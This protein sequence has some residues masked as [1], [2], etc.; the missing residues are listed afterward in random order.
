MYHFFF[1]D[2]KV[3]NH[4][5]QEL[6]V[7]VLSAQRMSTH[8]ILYLFIVSCSI[9]WS[10]VNGLNKTPSLNSYLLHC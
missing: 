2:S 4:S 7:R 8:Y 10:S 5:V 6:P 1:M 9:Y 3:D